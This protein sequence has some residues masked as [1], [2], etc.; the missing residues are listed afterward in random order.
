MKLIKSYFSKQAFKSNFILNLQMFI[1]L[2]FFF[3]ILYI[4]LFHAGSYYASEQTAPIKLYEETLL[5]LNSFAMGVIGAII[6]IVI[7]SIQFNYLMFKKSAVSVHCLPQNRAQIFT[8][9]YTAAGFIYLTGLITFTFTCQ[10]FLFPH[11]TMQA[12]LTAVYFILSSFAVFMFYYSLACLMH[13]ISGVFFIAPL[14][15]ASLFALLPLFA[16]ILFESFTE[17]LPL[18]SMNI[19]WFLGALLNSV[20][21]A[22]LGANVS[23]FSDIGIS[24]A[25]GVFTI[26][27]IFLLIYTISIKL[28]TKR[29]I[30]KTGQFLVFNFAKYILSIIIS[31]LCSVTVAV[32]I[33]HTLSI[34]Y[35]LSTLNMPQ[36]IL[37]LVLAFIA[38]VLTYFVALSI[39]SNFSFK[40]FSKTTLLQS[41]GTG[42]FISA[43]I[44]VLQMGG[45]GYSSYM[46]KAEHIEFISLRTS[47]YSNNIELHGISQ[48]TVTLQENEEAPLLFTQDEQKNDMLRF[49]EDYLQ[50]GMYLDVNKSDVLH[51]S[52]LTLTYTLKNGDIVSRE[53]VLPHTENIMQNEGSAQNILN[54]FAEDY[55]TISAIEQAL[56]ASTFSLSIIPVGQGEHEYASYKAIH[57]QGENVPDDFFETL[58]LEI[59]AQSEGENKFTTYSPIIEL[60]GNS[61][62]DELAPKSNI[63]ANVYIYAQSE[64]ISF[65]V[66]IDVSDDMEN[67][68]AMLDEIAAGQ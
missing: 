55:I 60:N 43:F 22:Q 7:A 35:N 32:S 46:P 33:K 1:T 13:I 5:Q 17:F 41:I 65:N 40:I 2:N 18:Y 31:L 53:F 9:K 19:D 24:D 29:N 51:Y 57:V 12:F 4:V 25:L 30:E 6:A 21:I 62:N 36:L 34:G 49:H 42:V 15:Y 56:K 10:I 48:H 59:E 61:E 20:S 64:Q 47:F 8:A 66:A 68:L 37:T 50:N 63:I 16:L 28:Y 38:A 54:N 52:R 3:I 14:L 45:L 39:L 44:I 58:F 11:F 23:E 26:V 67:T 27:V